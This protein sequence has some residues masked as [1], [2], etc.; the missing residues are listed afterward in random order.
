VTVVGPDLA[1]ADSY[2]TAALAMGRRGIT[3]LATLA[4]YESAV[5]TRD[6]EA[7]RSPGFPSLPN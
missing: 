5:I 3:W 1:I 2:A 7:F 6:A 4:G